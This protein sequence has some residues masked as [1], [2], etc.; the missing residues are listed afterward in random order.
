M[1]KSKKDNE[2]AEDDVISIALGEVAEESKVCNNCRFV[3][4]CTYEP[5]SKNDFLNDI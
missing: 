4:I 5:T 3:L 2:G 1:K